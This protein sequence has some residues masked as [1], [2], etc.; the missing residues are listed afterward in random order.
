MSDATAFR[1]D[2]IAQLAP[3]LPSGWALIP[4]QDS[5]DVLSADITVMLK[6]ATIGFAKQAPQGVYN[7]GWTFTV[8]SNSADAEMQENDL[9]A[10]VIVFLELLRPF[11]NLNGTTAT[12][13]LFQTNYLCY[14][15]TINTL[16]NRSQQ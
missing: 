3:V 2:V 14:D 16:T 12:K 4:Y 8:I 10:A 6:L 9:D 15:I 13:K 7:M 11:K 5:T 1:D